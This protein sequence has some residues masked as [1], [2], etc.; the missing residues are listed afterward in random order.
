M[1][2]LDSAT[3][4]GTQE[5]QFRLIDVLTWLAVWA[6]AL[7]VVPAISTARGLLYNE[8][9][10]VTQIIPPMIGWLVLGVFY[11]KHKQTVVVFIHVL[12]M[13]ICVATITSLWL[14]WQSLVFPVIASVISGTMCSFPMSLAKLIAGGVKR[15]G[16]DM[17]YLLISVLGGAAFFGGVCAL[18]GPA[19]VGYFSVEAVIYGV[20]LGS[21]AGLYQAATMSNSI[22]SWKIFSVS[23]RP[24]ARSAFVFGLL[25]SIFCWSINRFLSP[26]AIPMLRWSPLYLG[27]LGAVWG[28]LMHN[29]K[30]TEPRERRLS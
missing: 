13:I 12:P 15:N 20:G 25:G 14:N 29:S 11:I 5:N 22:G 19:I 9:P 24:M 16:S 3:Q 8:E 28:S 6:S 2:D 1:S 30:G 27:A 4:G 21:L 17:A 23:I 26:M 10:R 18:F 7:A